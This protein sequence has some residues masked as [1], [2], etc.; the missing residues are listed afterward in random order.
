MTTTPRGL[1][2]PPSG[3]NVPTPVRAADI[4]EAQ[5]GKIRVPLHRGNSVPS[6]RQAKEIEKSW[7]AADELETKRQQVVAERA[8]RTARRAARRDALAPDKRDQ[9]STINCIPPLGSTAPFDRVTTVA[10]SSKFEATNQVASDNY[11]D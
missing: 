2:I 1:K 6:A 4:E 5:A 9:L 7:R 10:S 11:S 3:Q 8:A